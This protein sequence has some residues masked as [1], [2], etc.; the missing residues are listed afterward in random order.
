MIQRKQVPIN[1]TVESRDIR[2]FAALALQSGIVHISALSYRHDSTEQC[3][4]SIN[5]NIDFM[6]H[7]PR[8]FSKRVQ[9]RSLQQQIYALFPSAVFK[10]S[11]N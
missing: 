4:P 9:E 8:H 11:L 7:F 2:C 3:K 5:F 10:S 1:N 6:S